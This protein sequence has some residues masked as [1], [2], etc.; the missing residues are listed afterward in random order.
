MVKIS[1]TI[2]E[3]VEASSFSRSRL[4]EHIRSGRLK[5]FKD[6]GRRHITAESLHQLVRELEAGE[7][8]R[9]A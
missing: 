2:T 8:G 3:A 7:S 9:A 6:G 5:S 4:Y 1:Y